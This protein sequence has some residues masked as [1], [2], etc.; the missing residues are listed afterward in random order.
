VNGIPPHEIT[1]PAAVVKQIGDFVD[2]V[3]SAISLIHYEDA[4]NPPGEHNGTGSFIA[5]NGIAHLV[6][7]EHVARHG[8][9]N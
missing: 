3:A 4:R 6:T 9:G 8:Q 1:P 7:C 2:S 5:L